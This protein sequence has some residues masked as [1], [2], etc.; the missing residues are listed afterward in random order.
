MT[1]SIARSVRIPVRRWIRWLRSG[2]RG[3]RSLCIDTCCT[4]DADDQQGCQD[5]AEQN[6]LFVFHCLLSDFYRYWLGY[7][8]PAN[9][10]AGECYVPVK[11]LWGNCVNHLLRIR[12]MA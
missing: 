3:R 7:L 1:V 9:I 12:G 4:N 10:L 5:S 11:S 6:R 2:R 8:Q